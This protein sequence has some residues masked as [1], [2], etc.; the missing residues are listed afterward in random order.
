MLLFRSEEHLDGWYRRRGIATGATLTLGQQW[1]LAR[2]WYADRL[3]PD[4]RRRTPEEAE[5]VFASLGLTGEFWRLRS[6][7]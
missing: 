3:A 7:G 6:A 2:L 1:E 5:A 4:W